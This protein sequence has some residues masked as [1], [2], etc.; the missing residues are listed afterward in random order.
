MF[1]DEDGCP[2]TVTGDSK[3]YHFPDS[4]RDGQLA[5]SNTDCKR[6]AH[7]PTDP[8]CA[9]RFHTTI[10]GP[11]LYG[12]HEIVLRFRVRLRRRIM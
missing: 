3:A 5:G 12:H 4:D 10:S 8:L 11:V 6:S 9:D 1:E 2:D 7:A